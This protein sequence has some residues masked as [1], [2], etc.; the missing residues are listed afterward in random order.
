MALLKT[1]IVS[2]WMTGTTERAALARPTVTLTR[3]CTRPLMVPAFMYFC[4]TAIWVCICLNFTIA[5]ASGDCFA[6][7][8]ISNWICQASNTFQPIRCMHATR[9][10]EHGVCLCGHKSH[11]LA[12]IIQ[13]ITGV[14]CKLTWSFSLCA[15]RKLCDLIAA[16]NC[17]HTR[18]R[19]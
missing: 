12:R 3:V 17:E 2:K 16:S 5:D 15:S 9:C 1:A 6:A 13:H 19:G 11:G 18:A 10:T 14:A 8:A 4:C 7:F